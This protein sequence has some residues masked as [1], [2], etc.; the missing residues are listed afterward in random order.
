MSFFLLAFSVGC[1]SLQKKEEKAELI[2]QSGI[3]LYEAKRYPEALRDLLRAYKMNPRS[4]AI[5]NAL[6]LTYHARG[7]SDLAVKY[8]LEALSLNSEYTEARNNLV[9]I[10]IETKDFSS[11]QKQ[12][13]IVKKDLT[14]SALDRVYINEGLLYFDQNKYA[15]AL[16]AFEKA[17]DYSRGNCSAHHLYGKSLFSLKRYPEAAASLDKAITFCQS[18]GSDESH[19]LSA[20]AYYRAG[21]KRKAAVRFEEITKLYP[22]GEHFEK[23]KSLLEIVKR[24]L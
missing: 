6:G 14:Y 2:M 11:A 12:I 7:R 24:E 13:A 9:R 18:V 4:P 21:D 10:Y 23:S 19:Y 22:N 16:K 1:Q 15:T 3:A 20:L 17:I 5:A 8:L